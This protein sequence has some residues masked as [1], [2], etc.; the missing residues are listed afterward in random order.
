MNKSEASLPHSERDKIM[1]LW[2]LR[3]YGGNAVL[4]EAEANELID[5]YDGLVEQLETVRELNRKAELR[6]ADAFMEARGLKEQKEALDKW[7]RDSAVRAAKNKD[8]ASG[9]GH[10]Y[11]QGYENACLDAEIIRDSNPASRSNDE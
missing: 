8:E 2:K 10:T 3:R 4:G 6:C 5:A 7:L 1:G 11:W 9:E